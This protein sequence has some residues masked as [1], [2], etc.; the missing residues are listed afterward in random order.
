MFKDH[1]VCEVGVEAAEHYH[2]SVADIQY[3]DEAG[4]LKRLV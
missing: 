4:G 1:H 2:L 3:P